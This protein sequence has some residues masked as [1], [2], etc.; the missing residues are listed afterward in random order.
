MNNNANSNTMKIENEG[1]N[2]M[3]DYLNVTERNLPLS[4]GAP[5]LDLETGEN[6]YWQGYLHDEGINNLEGYDIALMQV[7]NAFISMTEDDEKA[8]ELLRKHFKHEC[9]MDIDCLDL[10]KLKDDK[11]LHFYSDEEVDAMSPE[12]RVLLFLR[13]RLVSFMS[14]DRTQY[15][16][17]LIDTQTEKQHAKIREEVQAGI[18]INEYTLKSEGYSRLFD[19][20]Y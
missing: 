13:D 10:S 16:G 7:A 8:Q 19:F 5:K 2:N 18:R 3:R 15:V 14:Y 12:T 20:C 1:E 11:A 6:Y 17:E 9:Q 4:L